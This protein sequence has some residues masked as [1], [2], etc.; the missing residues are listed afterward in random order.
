MELPSIQ[1]TVEVESEGKLPFLNV[2]QHFSAASAGPLVIHDNCSN[3]M[4][5]RWQWFIQ[6][7][8]LSTF[9]GKVLAYHGCN[10]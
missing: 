9:D 6:V 2:L 4:A 5:L 8:A 1:F 10:G 3:C 7:S